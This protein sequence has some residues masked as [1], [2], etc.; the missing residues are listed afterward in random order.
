MASG[1][2]K[3]LVLVAS[4]EASSNS[5]TTHGTGFLISI[6]DKAYVVT[7][8][9]VAMNLE[10]SIVKFVITNPKKSTNVNARIISAPI[11]CNLNEP[12]IDLCL[13]ELPEYPASVLNTN[14]I[15]TL[16]LDSFI[17]IYTDMKAGDNV[18]AIGF[19]YAHTVEALSENKPNENL[20]A[21]NISG[22]VSDKFFI[23]KSYRPQNGYHEVEYN[24][25]FIKIATTDEVAHLQ[26]GISGSPVVEKK[27]GLLCGVLIGGSTDT[28]ITSQTS[29][30]I[31]FFTPVSFLV[32]MINRL[33]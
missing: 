2:E 21:I 14:G 32:D 6:R 23:E 5:Y 30:N 12:Y 26:E 25:H 17:N 11:Y 10:N 15:N 3:Y 4:Q 18:H 22:I 31:F 13:M 9:H 28:K 8:R 27:T 19:P 24:S 29:S 16:L 1:I 7:C 20:P 33:A